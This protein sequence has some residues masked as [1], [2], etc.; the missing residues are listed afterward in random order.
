MK[1][2]LLALIFF[3]LAFAGLAAG[4]L[5]RRRGLRGACN[6]AKASQDCRCESDLDSSMSAQTNCH[7]NKG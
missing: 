5:M 3:L 7:K 2:F 6:S 4:L 1:L